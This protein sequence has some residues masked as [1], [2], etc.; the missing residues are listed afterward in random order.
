M[1]FLLIILFSFLSIAE[2]AVI[3]NDSVE[4]DSLSKESLLEIYT[5]NMKNWDSGELITVVDFKGTNS[6]KNEFYGQLDISEK[7][8]KKIRLKKLFTG[9]VKPPKTISNEEEIINMV[10]DTPGCVAYIDKSKLKN[11]DKVK[12]VALFK[13]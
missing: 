9:K 13:N 3:V 11:T 4:I 10:S 8:I 1:K 7:S 12:V 6:S 2:I 5:L